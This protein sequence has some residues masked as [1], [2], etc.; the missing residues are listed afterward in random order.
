MRIWSDAGANVWYTSEESVAEVN[1]FIAE[2]VRTWKS[3][4]Q[5]SQLSEFTWKNM[6][7]GERIELI[8]VAA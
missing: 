2:T 6:Q 3:A 4:P 7:S 8:H 1:A 5:W